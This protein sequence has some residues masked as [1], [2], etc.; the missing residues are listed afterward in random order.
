MR[1]IITSD[2]DIKYDGRGIHYILIDRTSGEILLLRN[3]EV[4]VTADTTDLIK[5]IG[6]FEMKMI[7]ENILISDSN[8]PEFK[9]EIENSE[10]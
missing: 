2:K 3:N 6:E 1:V 8:A 4:L 7:A 10:Q 5:I 9:N